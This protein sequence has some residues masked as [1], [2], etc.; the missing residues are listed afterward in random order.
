MKPYFLPALL[1]FSIPLFSQDTL[2]IHATLNLQKCIDLSIQNNQQVKE[3]QYQSDFAKTNWSQAKGNLLPFINADITHGIND[4]RS[5][6]PFSNG[7]VDQNVGFANYG[8]NASF[9]L[10]NGNSARNNAKQSASNY[11]ASKMD[12]Q[13]QKDNITIAVML[14]Y[15]QEQS[16]SEQLEAALQQV[17]VTK[18]QEDRLKVL[19]D[20]GA[21]SPS[22]YY[23]LKGQRATDEMNV[24]N[25]ENSLVSAKLALTQL[26]NIT[27]DASLQFEK[28]ATSSLPQLYGADANEVFQQALQNMAVIKAASFKKSAAAFNVK[29]A[30]GALWP[31]LYLNGGLGTNY[32]SIATMSYLT[33]TSDMKT[34]QYVIIDNMKVP[35]FAPVNNYTSQKISYGSQAKN[36]LNSFISIGLRIPILQGLQAKNRV[37]QAKINLEKTTFEANAVQIELRREIEQAYI[38]MQSA[39]NRLKKLNEQAGDFGE[40]FRIAEIKFNEGAITSVDYL[41]AKNNLTQSQNNLIMAKYDYLLRTK[42]LDFYQSSLQF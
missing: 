25:L 18:S 34:D 37:E 40:S 38:N 7:Y 21:T 3:A 23:D 32:S 15:L 27:Y 33:G 22:S 36:N 19:N 35:V 2:P 4:G 16:I 20:Q 24:I 26:M 30:K 10:W 29:S 1:F 8:L 5:I 17:A 42:I 6:D 14:A 31:S 41:I 28:L 39:F 13:Q 9:L 11:E 12:W